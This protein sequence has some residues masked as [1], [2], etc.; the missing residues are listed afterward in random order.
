MAYMIAVGGQGMRRRR[1]GSLWPG[2]LKVGNESGFA[3][4]GGTGTLSPKATV[5]S[6][7]TRVHT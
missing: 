4:I 1:R 5:D 2:E 7:T 6:S 3:V